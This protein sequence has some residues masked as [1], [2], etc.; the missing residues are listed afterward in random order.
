MTDKHKLIIGGVVC[1]LLPLMG[2][3]IGY[4]Q[5]ECPKPDR[6]LYDSLAAENKYLSESAAR[7]IA[8]ADSL[9]SAE[10]KEVPVKVIYKK[11]ALRL[12]DN[13]SLDTLRAILLR[14]PSE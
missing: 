12:S 7:A 14:S 2:G 6:A 5:K 4:S 3:I 10:P 8:I 11:H 1:I 13:P 9:A